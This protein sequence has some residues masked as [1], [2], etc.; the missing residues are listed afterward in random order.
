MQFLFRVAG[1]LLLGLALAGCGGGGGGGGSSNSGS[2]G[3]TSNGDGAW[4][5]FN[6]N[7][8]TVSGYEG[9]SIRFQITA[10]A[11][12]S[13]DK[14]FNIAIIDS[15]GVITTDVN[16]RSL[17]QLQYQADL[18][19]SSRLSAGTHQAS[20][21]VRLCEDDPLICRTPLPGSPWR[22]PLTVSLKSKA[23]AAKRLSVTPSALSVVAYPGEAMTVDIAA[24]ISGDLVGENFQIGVID[25]AGVTSGSVSNFTPQGFNATLATSTSLGQGDYSSNVE[26]RL[27]RDD[28]RTCSLPVPGSPW[29][30][31]LKVQVK[32]PVNLSSLQALPGVGAWSTYQGNASHTG[33]VAATFDVAKFSRRW[34]VP[35]K[36]NYDLPLNSAASDNG[37]VYVTRTEGGF[38]NAEVVAISEATGAELWRTPLGPISHVNP[39]AAANGQVY[40]TTTGHA[41]TF[42]WVFDQRD[43]SLLSKTALTSQWDSYMAP[44][45]VGTD[46]YTDSGYYGGMVKFSAAGK[47]LTWSA[48]LPQYD[49]WTPAVD[50]RDAYAYMDGKLHAVNVVTGAV[51]WTVTDPGN[52]WSGYAGAPVVLADNLAFV[53][54]GGRLLAFDTARHVIAWTVAGSV[55]GQPAYGNGAVYVLNANGTVLEARTPADGSLQ[56]TSESLGTG[57]NT[58]VIVTRNLAFVSSPLRTT[59]IDLATH[60]IVWAYPSGG[61]LSISAN[62][63]LYILSNLGALSAVNLQ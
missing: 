26:I 4:L 19:T 31:S 50:T 22:V 36:W 42:L 57:R 60:K 61:D 46:V 21:E 43:G 62:G 10:T 9:E 5:T 15:T 14:T 48:D 37:A 49:S 47:S 27:C 16:L 63:V 2:P 53:A 12:R 40:V 33:Y 56:W 34:N 58:H 1:P 32:S 13:F 18:A 55:A 59:A 23:E 17:S 8:A 25:P 29:I 44:T 54:N 20:L 38:G 7:P 24:Q 28:P 52:N 45:V 41:D 51:D 35:A 6:P 3:P 30:V 11:T 39:P